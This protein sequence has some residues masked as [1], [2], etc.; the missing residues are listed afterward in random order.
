MREQYQRPTAEHGPPAKNANKLVVLCKVKRQAY[1]HVCDV[2][3]MSGEQN[4]DFGGFLKKLKN[5]NS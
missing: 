4:V 3:N 1:A 2:R 5:N